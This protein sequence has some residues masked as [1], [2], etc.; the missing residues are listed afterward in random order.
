MNIGRFCLLFGT[1]I[2][3]LAP[4]T[5]RGI[6]LGQ[7]DT[8]EDG[9]IAGWSSGGTIF[10]HPDGA[11]GNNDHFL[12]VPSG[13]SGASPFLQVFNQSQW[14]G[15]YLAAG[16]TGVEM[17]L[18]NDHTITLHVRIAVSEKTSGRNV[19]GYAST[20]ALDLPSDGIWHHALFS[21]AAFRRH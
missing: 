18:M 20:T 11:A 3:F 9:T 7:V 10:V 2:L 19:P 5:S 14:L 21:L 8:F 1:A 16:V 12:V 13:I 4:A 17:D 6:T 15:N